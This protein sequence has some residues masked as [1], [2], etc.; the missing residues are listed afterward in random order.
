MLILITCLLTALLLPSR[1]ADAALLQL[2]DGVIDTE[3]APNRIAADRLSG[4]YYIHFDR[5]PSTAEREQLAS[6]GARLHQ[7]LPTGFWYVEL[8]DV[9]PTQLTPA[10]H[11][12]GDIR[13]ED[14]LALQ[15]RRGQLHSA[16]YT[17]GGELQVI[18]RAYRYE[19]G[20]AAQI[21]ALAKAAGWQ[22]LARN[23]R[24]RRLTLALPE[25]DLLR[26]AEVKTVRWI[27][28]VPPPPRRFNDGARANM[29]VDGLQEPYYALDGSGTVA[30]VWDG[31]TVSTLHPD[32]DDRLVLE[33]PQDTDQHA[34]HVAGTM[35]GD[36]GNSDNNGGY[37][38]QWRGMAPAA[39]L[40][41]WDWDD[42]PDEYVDAAEDLGLVVSNNS[43]GY[44]VEP[45]YCDFYGDYAAFC[46]EVD[47]VVPGWLVSVQFA[48]GNERGWNECGQNSNSYANIP[49][50][51]PAKNIL[52]IGAINSNNS[53]MTGFSSWGPVD[54]G[55][56]KPD[57]CA[58]GCETSGYI[59]STLPPQGYGGPGW[60]G[61]SMAAPAASGVVTL[62][63]QAYHERYGSTPYPS[64][65][66]GLLIQ[67]AEDLGTSGPNFQ[68]G[69]GGI[70]AQAA[71]EQLYHEDF[72]EG[73]LL[74]ESE[75][76]REF[77]I[78]AGTER[79]RVTLVWDDFPGTE[80]AGR[81]LINDLDLR[82]TDPGGTT[83][84]PWVLDADNPSQPA[85]TGDDSLNNVEQVEVTSPQPGSWTV[86]V[87]GVLP[88]GYQLFS[89]LLPH[90]NDRIALQHE[91]ADTLFQQA[92]GT[93]LNC[94]IDG[95]YGFDPAGS[96]LYWF[97]DNGGEG[98]VPLEPAGDDTYT[99][100][101]PLSVDGTIQYYFQA[102]DLVG[103]EVRLPPGAPLGLFSCFVA[104]GEGTWAEP[105][106]LL[107]FALQPLYPNPFN[108]TTRCGFS[109]AHAGW[110]RLA[111]F[112]LLGREMMVLREGNLAAGVYHVELDGSEL[113]AGIYLVRLQQA[114]RSQTRKALLVK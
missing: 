24:F 100:I 5:L 7:Y 97:D 66:K 110:T 82:L 19:A 78:A 83:F 35:A 13:L 107:Q 111:V 90:D 50:P 94:T 63:Q 98:E 36:G 84:L 99:A 22:V 18:V 113:P 4:F 81:T 28:P 95:A 26:L 106:A 91:P 101:L 96:G 57:I 73:W 27:E 1:G 21:Q 37:D 8:D 3:T 72:V 60:C 93:V 69:W 54:D 31:G 61:T 6:A 58:P 114:E 87:T 70:D 108:P 45:P 42:T 112:D 2:R 40:H 75:Y 71:V 38:L 102:A 51:A 53:T 86:T 9:V 32:F 88:M 77:N 41:S 52:T 16:A 105:A 11:W 10:P 79:L 20:F 92:E 76:T 68:Y 80:N 109:L 65:L 25:G 39:S 64:L 34:T 43:W 44:G 89:L 67:T 30:G 55:R 17:A 23:D 103:D 49:P 14:K 29:Q 85:V 62:L 47:E 56:I 59:K 33:D 12:I 48:V 74:A 46:V 15:L 104:T